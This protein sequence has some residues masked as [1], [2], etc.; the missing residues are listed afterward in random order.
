MERDATDLSTVGKC[1]GISGMMATIKQ[2]WKIIRRFLL[3]SMK[4]LDLPCLA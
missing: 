2:A 3:G 1:G 4:W